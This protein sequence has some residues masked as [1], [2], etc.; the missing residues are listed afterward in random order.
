MVR[1]DEHMSFV[2]LFCGCG[3]FDLGF[4]N[5]GFKCKAA[6]DIDKTAIKNYS[7]YF[8][9][10]AT[11]C[12]LSQDISAGEFEDIDVVLAGP[13]C[14]GFSTAGKRR[15]DDPRNHL[16]LRAT[17][18]ALA[19]NPKVFVLENV[20]GVVAGKHKKYWDTAHSMLKNCYQI[21]ELSV[22]AEDVGLAQSRKRRIL[23]AWRT[24]RNVNISLPIK[25]SKTLRQ[26]IS[27][28]DEALPNHNKRILD[29]G[30]D[31][32]LIAQKIKPGQKL[33]NARGGDR[34]IHTW[35]I[36]EVFGRTNI[37]ERKVLEAILKLRRRNRLRDYGDADPVTA[38]AIV[39]ELKIQ[40]KDILI[41]LIQKNYVRKLDRR[42]DLTH[43]FN[44]KF[45]R[46]RWDAPSPTVDTRFGSPRYFLHPDENRGL[47]V[48]E[49]AR[50]QG[51]PDN[52]EF[53]GNES[54]QYRLVGNAV[55]PA[56][57]EEIGKVVREF[58]V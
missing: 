14:Q 58:L 57:S 28:I 13:P 15:Y 7:N 8:A 32:C 48:R 17:E 23:I 51:F 53:M 27:I 37:K 10:K 18:I 3:G 19:I 42:Y 39:A 41:S 24:G 22:N 45:R 47:T 11:E 21:Q 46:L 16:L 20:N 12:D 38:N 43:T 44:G 5:A 56:L 34:S 1:Q 55:P 29:D 49:A 26:A 54:S 4:V 36:P 35:H 40:V 31:C 52:Y 9:H 6:F 33:S 2:S 25:R 50:I 30:S